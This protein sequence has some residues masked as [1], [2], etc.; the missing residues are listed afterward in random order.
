MATLG[1]GP[2]GGGLE[3]SLAP[4]ASGGG[5]PP[6]SPT[7]NALN[8]AAAGSA[9]ELVDSVQSPI[10]LENLLG[11]KEAVISTLWEALKGSPPP[12][13]ELTGEAPGLGEEPGLGPGGPPLI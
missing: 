3:P 10:E 11:S 8:D 13:P 5:M 1:A 7:E 12:P 9:Q 2:L 6:A 4:S